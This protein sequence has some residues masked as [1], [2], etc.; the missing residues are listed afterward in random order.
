MEGSPGFA[1]DEHL[2]QLA[3]SDLTALGHRT[4]MM[5]AAE[6]RDPRLGQWIA[7]HLDSADAEIR[8]AALN[9]LNHPWHAPYFEKV[10]QIALA[11]DSR[12]ASAAVRALAGMGSDDAVAVLRRIAAEADSPTARLSRVLLKGL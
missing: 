1:A 12:E 4:V 6:S 3:N 2:L 7:S 10:A 8:L 11:G 9:S 5:A